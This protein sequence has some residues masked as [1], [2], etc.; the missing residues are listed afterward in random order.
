MEIWDLYDEKGNITGKEVKRGDE[1]PDGYY[2]LAVHVWIK[3]SSGKYLISK[4]ADNKKSFPSMWDCVVGAVIKGE[5]S[6]QAALREVKEEV[7]LDLSQNNA[8]KSFSYIVKTVDGKKINRIVN[9]YIFEYDGLVDLKNALTDEVVEVKW[10]SKDEINKL[11]ETN[12]MVP[13]LNYFT[14]NSNF[15]GNNDI[16]R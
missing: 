4:R 15:L 2:H 13:T 6:I 14:T 5:T 8:K 3:N 9:V 16:E 7:G 12:Q 11:L 10:M 1:I